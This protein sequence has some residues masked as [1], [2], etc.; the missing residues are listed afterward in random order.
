MDPTVVCVLFRGYNGVHTAENNP[1]VLLND[2]FT[3]WYVGILDCEIVS[4]SNKEY[5][6]HH[7]RV[8]PL[9]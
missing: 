2:M 6:A 1:V 3:D 4:C 9:A 7:T 5:S 8:G